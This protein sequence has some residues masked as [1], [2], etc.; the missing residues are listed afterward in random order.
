MKWTTSCLASLF[1][2]AAAGS[3]A[4]IG[5]HVIFSYP[6]TTPP[7]RL[8]DLIQAGEVGGIILFGENVTEDLPE[9]IERILSTYRESPAYS[10]TPL[11]IMT[12]Q[13]GGQIRRLPGAPEQSAREVGDSADPFA[14]AGETGAGAAETLKSY[15]MNVN[16]APVLD[17]YREEGDFTDHYGRSYSDNTTVVSGCAAQFVEDQQRTNVL[18]TAKHFPGLGA[19]STEE[20]TDGRPVTINLS[21]DEIRAVDEVPYHDVIRAGVAMVMPS[22]AIYPALDAERPA[23]MSSRWIQEELRGR[24]GY[25]GVIITDA[26]EAG[27]LGA[28]S[29]DGNRALL[30][31]K[32]G[33]DLLLA[34]G[35]NV[36]QGESIVAALRA[37]LESGELSQEELDASRKRVQGVRARLA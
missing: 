32:A 33:V 25:D 27:S 4:R 15:N 6:G 34:S 9:T 3:K 20:N 11:L 23:G 36:T 21:L 2:L 5:Q 1:G 18:A 35:R 30:A 7:D 29:D 17:V 16:L 10:G 31:K 8:F 19:A 28:F 26:I 13:E 12:D 37:A 24:L 22:W 14:A